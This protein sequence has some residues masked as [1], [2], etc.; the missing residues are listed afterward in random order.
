M[1]QAEDRETWSS[2]AGFVLAA[3]GSAV[4]L[5]NV[6][7]FP[8]ITGEYGGG[9]FVLLYLICIAI[10]GIPLLIA[11]MVIG[12]QTQNGPVGAFIQLADRA[13]GGAPWRLAG[14]FAI[15]VSFL[16]LS[17]YSVVGGWSFAY[18]F[19]AFTGEVVAGNPTDIREI[20]GA[21]TGD[22]VWSVIAHGAFMTST[23]AI[24]YGGVTDGIEKAARVLM[25]M[26]G[27]LLF[28][29]LVY[30]LSS[31]GASEALNFMFAPRWGTLLSS[32]NAIMEALGHAFF[33]L[34][35]GMGA[36][37]VY[38]SY[39]SKE[40]SLFKTSL[41]VGF[42]DT[43]VALSAG[44]VI[45]GIIFA[46]GGDPARGPGLV[47]QT[48]PVLFS[49]IPGGQFVAIGFFVLLTF[50]ALTSGISLLEV[51]VS[52]FV[53]E[54]DLSR[55]SASVLFGGAI[56]VFGIPSVL[57][58]STLGAYKIPLA[59]KCHHFFG[60]LDYLISNWALVTGGLV[61]ATF[62]GWAVPEDV[63]YREIEDD[64]FGRRF[65]GLW[66]WLTRVVAPVAIVIVMLNTA[67]VFSGDSQESASEKTF[68]SCWAVENQA[69]EGSSE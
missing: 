60:V 32:P 43:I 7:K 37:L 48:M 52:Y 21:F 39:L 19:K 61:I 46:H 5:G 34:S 22:P 20:F 11:E 15:L 59:G 51:V 44:I 53:D 54:T 1:A 36:M 38:G 45:F 18:A 12:R 24:V 27:V 66:K 65:F 58:F 26:F 33:T 25:P 64:A 9:A 40:E 6:W 63:W 56:F 17:F 62:V 69:D 29:L 55:Q 49:K 47:F 3:V 50:A 16:L 2:S 14:F 30:S 13:R 35:L 57:S 8:Y 67:G 31:Q 42:F 41:A 28:G 10:V 4:G 23:I 68:A